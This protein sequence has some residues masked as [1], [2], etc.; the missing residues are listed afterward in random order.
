MK[1]YFED[2]AVII[3]WGDAREVL[4][5]LGPVDHVI[6]DPPYTERTHRRALTNKAENGSGRYRQGGAAPKQEW[7]FLWATPGLRDAAL[8]QDV[9]GDRGAERG[10]RGGV[11]AEL[12]FCDECGLEE[13]L[14]VCSACGGTFCGDCLPGTEHFECSK[15]A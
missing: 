9:P 1:P 5:K 15:E 11:M 10:A 4:P 3:Y 7:P 13:E 6:T 14:Q 2:D 8:R 12:T